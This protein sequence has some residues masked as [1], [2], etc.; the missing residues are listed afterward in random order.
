M[1][2]STDQFILR[3]ATTLKTLSTYLCDG[4]GGPRGAA[5]AYYRDEVPAGRLALSAAGCRPEEIE[6]V[7]VSRR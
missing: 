1:S 3:H 2:A 6:A 5:C 7:L 4:P